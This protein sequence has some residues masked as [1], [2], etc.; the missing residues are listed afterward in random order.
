MEKIPQ[1]KVEVKLMAFRNQLGKGVKGNR[2]TLDAVRH[3]T[4]EDASDAN[5][6]ANGSATTQKHNS[7]EM[8]ITQR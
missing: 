3:F 5:N 7:N 6:D 1:Q 2:D 4:S 8:L